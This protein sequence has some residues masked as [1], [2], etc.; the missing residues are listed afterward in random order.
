MG[1]ANTAWL[2]ELEN[3]VIAELVQQWIWFYPLTETMHI[4]GL[5]ILFGSIAMFDL[6][7]LGFSRQLLVTDLA[8][9]L[10]PCAYL[11][12]GLVLISGFLLFAVDATAIAANPAFRL[13]LMLVFAAGIN[14]IVFHI[15]PYSSVKTWNCRVASPLAVR[16]IA[17]TSLL[18]WSAVILCGRLIA[19]I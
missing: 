5:A 10:L 18:L 11:S 3:S 15:G 6:R 14:A 19:Y 8:Q 17:V 9:H 2:T 12:F 1:A 16:F 13:K 4:L 7:L